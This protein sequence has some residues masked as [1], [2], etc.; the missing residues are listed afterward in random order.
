MATIKLMFALI[1]KVGSDKTL[2]VATI[3]VNCHTAAWDSVA[4]VVFI[5]LLCNQALSA[6][7]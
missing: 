3:F 4:L 1:A 6:S 2:F 7:Q 5:S